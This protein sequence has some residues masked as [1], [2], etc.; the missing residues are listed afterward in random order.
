MD[1]F[2]SRFFLAVLPVGTVLGEFHRSGLGTGWSG[3][4]ETI[5]LSE[6]KRMKTA[7]SSRIEGQGLF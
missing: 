1:R 4:I 5:G 2:F 7:H 6:Q 3:L